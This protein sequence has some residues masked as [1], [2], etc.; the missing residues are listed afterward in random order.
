MTNQEVLKQCLQ[1]IAEDFAAAIMRIPPRGEVEPSPFWLH[2]EMVERFKVLQKSS[3]ERGMNILEVGCGAHAI[4][5]VTLAYMV[6]SNGRVVAVDIGRWEHVE[7]ILNLA[8]I[9]QRV[10]PLALDA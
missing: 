6:G 8:G 2:F 10:F 1:E 4:T 7:E 5:T 9:R 3:I